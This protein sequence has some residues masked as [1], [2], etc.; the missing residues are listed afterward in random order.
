MQPVLGAQKN[1]IQQES[2]YEHIALLPW[3]AITKLL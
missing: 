2:D 3:K 1:F